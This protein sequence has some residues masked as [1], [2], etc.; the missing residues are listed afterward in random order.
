M[1]QGSYPVP[2][3]GSCAESLVPRV[4]VFLKRRDLMGGEEGH[5]TQKELVLIP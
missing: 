1:A 5:C 3:R 4:V 2:P